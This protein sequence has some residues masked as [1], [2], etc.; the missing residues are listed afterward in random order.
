MPCKGGSRH[1]ASAH[2]CLEG[3]A[4]GVDRSYGWLRESRTL[5]L[6]G[7][8]SLDFKFG[9]LFFFFFFLRILAHQP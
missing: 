2:H 9:S 1:A 8:K 6:F 7:L 4:S 5:D 3:M